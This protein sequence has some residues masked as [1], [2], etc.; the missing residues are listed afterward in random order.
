LTIP[1]QG[2]ERCP[3]HFECTTSRIF[4]REDETVPSVVQNLLQTE[5]ELEDGVFLSSDQS[6]IYGGDVW[7]QKIKEGLSAA[8]LVISCSASGLWFVRGSISRRVP[9][10]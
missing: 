1:A 10:G 6:R 2:L 3:V 9:H 4:L 7:L 5:L 8:E